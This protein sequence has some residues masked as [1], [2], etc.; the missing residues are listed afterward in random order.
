[1]EELEQQEEQLRFATFDHD[2][3]IALGDT[4]YRT[5]RERNLAV[6]IDVRAF[7]QILFHLAMA[8]TTP[9]NDQW[10]ERK[11]NVVLRFHCASYRMGRRLAE[12]G[13]TIAEHSFVDPMTFSP[14]GGSF[15]VRLKSGGVIGA[16]TVSGL[17]QEEDHALVVSVLQDNPGLREG[18]FMQKKRF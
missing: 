17:P 16:V 14:F 2:T 13:E 4:L 11:S 10:V 3:A 8:G 6:T 12:S 1:M 18:A 9:D 5:A 15:P 7:G